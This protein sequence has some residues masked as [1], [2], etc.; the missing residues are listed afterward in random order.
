[1]ERRIP[2]NDS[3]VIGSP[4]PP[5]PYR[6]RLA[7]PN[8]RFDVPAVITRAPGVSRLFVGD[9]EGRIFS[10]EDRRDASRADVFLEL[11]GLGKDRNG[12]EVARQV[13][14][15]EFH[16]DFEI[17]RYFYVFTR[18][19]RPDPVRSRLSRFEAL[20]SRPGE[21]P[22]A[23]PDSELILMEFP[24]IGHSGGTIKFGPDG[25][26]YIGTGDGGG[27]GD[28][29]NTGRARNHI[30]A[31][32]LRIG[33]EPDGEPDH[34]TACN[35]CAD[36]GPFD[37]T[38]PPDNPFVNDTD[39]APEVWA[40]GFRNPWRFSFD[41]DNGDLYV[42][43]VGQ[44]AREEIDVVVAGGDYGW[45]EME[46][47]QCYGGGGC[48]VKEPNEVN[49]DGLTMPLV[50]YSIAGSRCAVIGLGV[51]R[52]CEV[53][54]FDG[55]YFYGDFCTGDVFALVWDGQSVTDLGSVWT[56]SEGVDMIRGGGTNAHGDVYVAA[57]N[58]PFPGGP[59]EGVVYRITASR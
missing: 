1:M 46:G 28:Q 2:W 57:S 35:T 8:L 9:L 42:A 53:P 3:R 6:T 47:F 4:E 23:N 11:E 19:R 22:K 48:D 38:I 26:L 52:S 58:V 20:P 34:P 54:A 27:G 39:F 33:V 36:L 41:P 31:K 29:Y 25:Y 15:L 21:P 12:R 32:I 45:S 5:S 7:F 10:F 44:N 16:P 24:S 59:Q 40:W 17:N 18:L 37:Y 50:D 56:P 51:Y 14:G 49:D 55:V 30:L 13:V 43:D